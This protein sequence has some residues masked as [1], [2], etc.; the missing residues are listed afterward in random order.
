MERLTMSIKEVSEQL[1]VSLPTAH[2]IVNSDGFP[3]LRLGRRKVIPVAGFMEW[4][5]SN[6]SYTAE[7]KQRK[8][9]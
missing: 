5:K 2:K 8:M 1:G 9:T 7:E 3:V 4:M 6:S